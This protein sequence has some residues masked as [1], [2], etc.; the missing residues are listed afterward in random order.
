MADKLAMKDAEWRRFQRGCLDALALNI[1][2]GHTTCEDI[3]N[4]TSAILALAQTEQVRQ[5]LRPT[6]EKRQ[7]AKAGLDR[8]TRGAGTPAGV[9]LHGIPVGR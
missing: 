1:E 4:I 5:Q 7:P 6:G 9:G 2:Q 3:F 8:T